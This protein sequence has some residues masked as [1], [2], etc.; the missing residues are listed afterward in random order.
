MASHASSTQSNHNEN[1]KIEEKPEKN[2]MAKKYTFKGFELWEVEETVEIICKLD[3][4]LIFNCEM[5][6]I[7]DDVVILIFKFLPASEFMRL[8]RVNTQFYSC[9]YKAWSIQ[10]D[11]KCH[12]I[13][14]QQFAELKLRILFHSKTCFSNFVRLI[15]S[16]TDGPSTHMIFK[17]LE[18]FKKLETVVLENITIDPNFC[19]HSHCTARQLISTWN[20]SAS[21]GDYLPILCFESA[22]A[23]GKGFCNLTFLRTSF[24]MFLDWFEKIMEKLP[25]LVTLLITF[26]GEFNESHVA[27]FCAGLRSQ[28]LRN[29][30][31]EFQH[32]PSADVFSLLASAIDAVSSHNNQPMSNQIICGGTPAKQHK[33]GISGNSDALRLQIFVSVSSCITESDFKRGCGRHF[34]FKNC[35]FRYLKVFEYGA[36]QH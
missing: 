5:G 25:S 17:H 4:T 12:K 32:A 11:F 36:V 29:L 6:Q 33:F 22:F 14:G 20:I 1:A 9:A 23:Y 24:V 2:V 30:F 18:K 19:F 31:I 16:N 28:R 10:K 7:K 21:R 34:N 13:F 8:A 27:P 26:S 15:L 35:D 3:P